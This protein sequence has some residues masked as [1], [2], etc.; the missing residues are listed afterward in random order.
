[1]DWK[2]QLNRATAAL[3]GVTESEAVKSLT[4][5]ARQTASN[6]ARAARQGAA[7]AAE[8][9]VEATSDPA[10]VKLHYMKAEVSIVSPSDGL[11]IA[12]PQAGVLVISDPEGNGLVISLTPSQ[13]QVTET[14]GVV[15]KLND[16]TYDVGTED[17]VNVVVVKA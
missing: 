1:M 9:V 14:V 15:K 13:A 7:N 2:E 11:N 10:T 12:R 6:L 5:K 4:S 8:A 3:R 17:G 16:T